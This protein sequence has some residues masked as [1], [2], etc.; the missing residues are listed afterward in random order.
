MSQQDKVRTVLPQTHILTKRVLLSILDN[1]LQKD[2][3]TNT[4]MEKHK[5]IKCLAIINIFLRVK[6]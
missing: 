3:I 5:E 4:S 6:T 2:S 1:P